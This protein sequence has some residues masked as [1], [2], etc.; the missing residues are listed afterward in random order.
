MPLGLISARSLYV[1][2]LSWPPDTE[3]D[4]PDSTIKKPRIMADVQSQLR[5]FQQYK[6]SASSNRDIWVW[7]LSVEVRA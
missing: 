1:L 5:K 3:I 6:P 2:E 7:A 4:V